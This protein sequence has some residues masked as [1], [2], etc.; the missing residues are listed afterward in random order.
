MKGKLT[1]RLELEITE[2][3]VNRRFPLRGLPACQGLKSCYFAGYFQLWLIMQSKF[4]VL[5]CQF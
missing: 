4:A 2:G 3:G 1:L 5:D